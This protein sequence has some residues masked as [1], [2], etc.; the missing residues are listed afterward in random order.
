VWALLDGEARKTKAAGQ[1]PP[2][3]HPARAS[4]QERVAQRIE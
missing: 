2:L 1:P 4:P 3:L